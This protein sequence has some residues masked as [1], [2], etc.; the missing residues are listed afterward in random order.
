[1]AMASQMQELFERLTRSDFRSRFT[2]GSEEREYLVAKGWVTILSHANDFL[3]SRLAPASPRGDGKQTPMKGHPVF[4]AQ[5]ATATCCRRC[6]AK[7]HGIAS[8][9][10]LDVHQVNHLVDAIRYWLEDQAGGHH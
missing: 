6:L 7:W 3:Q 2:L 4:I 8:G 10:E 1:M 5:H 9:I